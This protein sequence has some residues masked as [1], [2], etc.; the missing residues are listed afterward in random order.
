MKAEPAEDESLEEALCTMMN[1][2]GPETEEVDNF[3]A[4]QEAANEM[5]EDDC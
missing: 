1:D 5:H 2:M 3:D 4:D